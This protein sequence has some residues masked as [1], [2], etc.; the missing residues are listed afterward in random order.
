MN[1]QIE[2]VSRQL[3][4]PNW[5]LAKQQRLS[6]LAVSTDARY[7][8]GALYLA[9][10]GILTHELC[11][12]DAELWLA[13][14]RTLLPEAVTRAGPAPEHAL[15]LSSPHIGP[16][17]T[18]RLAVH[19]DG[20]EVTANTGARWTVNTSG[21]AGSNNTDDLFIGSALATIALRW[22]SQQR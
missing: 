11:G 2:R 3:L 20:V 17:L 9:G 18:L 14:I 5:T 13:R 6:A 19:G 16:L 7:G 12:P 8:L 10:A 4:L 1:G 15:M 22:F 21:L